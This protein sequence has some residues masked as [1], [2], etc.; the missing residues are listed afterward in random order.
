MQQLAEGG[1]RGG[2]YAENGP[3]VRRE[4]TGVDFEDLDITMELNRQADLV[5]NDVISLFRDLRNEGATVQDID[6]LRRLAADIRASDFS[7]N[8][9]LL[10]EES[11]LALTLVEQLELALS[12]TTGD[13]DGGVRA[14]AVEEIPEEHREII[15]DYYRRLGQAEDGTEER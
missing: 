12:R 6:E 15:A 3:D 2:Q 7:G 13:A 8:P 5:S 14:N 9:A 4:S 1:Y 10:E 11:R